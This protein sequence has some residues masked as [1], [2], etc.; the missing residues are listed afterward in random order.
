MIKNI[1]QN[2]MD[3]QQIEQLQN[4]TSHIPDHENIRGAAHYQ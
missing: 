1:L 2:N 4:E 3:N